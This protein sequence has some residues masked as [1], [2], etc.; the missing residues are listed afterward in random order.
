MPIKEPSGNC[1][2]DIALLEPTI[3]HGPCNVGL[4]YS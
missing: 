1:A 2:T 4:V 3:V